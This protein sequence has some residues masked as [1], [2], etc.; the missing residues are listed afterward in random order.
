MM[1]MSVDVLKIF[2]LQ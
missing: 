2:F 1:R